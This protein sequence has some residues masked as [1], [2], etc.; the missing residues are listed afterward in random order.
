[1]GCSN[2]LHTNYSRYGPVFPALCPPPIIE[3]CQWRIEA[4]EYNPEKS[5]SFFANY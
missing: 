4:V 1:M 5:A 2:G 3:R